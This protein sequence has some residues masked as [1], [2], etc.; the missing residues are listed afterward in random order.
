MVSAHILPQIAES[1]N[2]ILQIVQ[3]EDMLEDFLRIKT[4]FLTI[5]GSL[6]ITDK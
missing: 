1:N 2:N 6:E 5:Q 3:L 4:Y